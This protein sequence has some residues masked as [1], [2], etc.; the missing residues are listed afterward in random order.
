MKT[1]V[2]LIILTTLIV[3]F[4][5]SQTTIINPATNGGFESG[6]TF[7]LN[8][9]TLV[10]HTTNQWVLG[11]TPGGQSGARCA[12]ISN[13]SPNWTYSNITS[14]TSHFYRSITVP[15]GETIINLSFKWK[16][17]G[18]SGYD[19][20]LVYTN[21]VAPT[22]G[23]PASSTTAWGTA[24][25][26]GGPYNSNTTWQN[27]NI[28]LPAGLA[29]TT[30]NLIFTWQNDG[31]VG[32]NP[33]SAVDDI[34][35]VS[36]P[37]FLMDNTPVTT[38]SGIFVDDGNAFNY[39]TSKDYIKT[40]T[41]SSAGMS[42]Q[43]VF[44]SFVMGDAD[45]Y[46]TIYDGPNIGSPS[47]GTFNSTTGSPGTVVAY[48]ATGQL[49]F[50]WHSDNNG[51]GAGWSANIS[52][53]SPPLVGESCTN[54]Q[55]LSTMTSPF[56]GTTVG[57]ASDISTC[58]SGYPDR[59]F[60][61][62]VPNGCNIDI[63]QSVNNYDSYHY[64][65]YGSSCPGT[66]IYCIDD[67]DTQHN[68]W[69]NTTGSTQRV[70]FIVDGYSGSGTFT[71]EWLLTCCGPPTTVTATASTTL[72]SPGD[73]VTFN[74]SSH[75]GGACSSGNWEYQWEDNLGNVLQAW[76]TTSSY[77]ETMGPVGTY[78]Y[79]LYM[80]CSACPGTITQSSMLTVNVQ[81]CSTC[82]NAEVIGSLPYTYTGATCNMCDNYSSAN[83]C[84]SSYLNGDDFVFKYTPSVDIDIQVDITAAQT[85]S[86]VIISE[87]CPDVGTCV[88]TVTSGS[89]YSSSG[90]PFSLTA[91]TSYYIV[92][93]TYP[94]PQCLTDFT[95]D[96]TI[97]CDPPT[98]ITLSQNP[99]T[100]S[101]TPGTNVTLSY[102]THTGGTCAGT[103]QFQWE[104]DLGN[105]LQ[106]WSTTSNYSQVYNN[107]ETIWLYMRCTDCPGDIFGQS[108][109][110]IVADCEW[111]VC[112]EDSY[113]D[114]WNGGEIEVI[115]DGSSLGF[116]TLASGT[117]P[118][119]YIIYIVDGADITIDYSS[120][121]FS[122]ENEY[123]LFDMDGNPIHD[124][125]VGGSTPAD[126]TYSNAYCGMIPNCVTTT[127]ND[128]LCDGMLEWD[129][130]GFAPDG[131]NLYFGTNNPPTNIINGTDIGNVTS[132]DVSPLIPGQT[133][134]W[135]IIPYNTTYGS[136]VGCSVWSFYYQTAPVTPDANA[137]PPAVSPGGTVLL[138]ATSS[139]PVLWF[140]DKCEGNVISSSTTFST[141]PPYSATY[142]LAAYNGCYS[143]CDSVYVQVVQPCQA[144]A[145]ANGIVDTIQIC[146]GDP[147]DL[148]AAA[149][150][151]YMM[152]NDFNDGSIGVGWNSNCSPMFNNPCLASG[153]GSTYLWVGDAS[154]FPRDLVTQEYT[155]VAGCQICF[156]FAMAIQSDASPCEGPD[157]VDEGVSL[158][159]STDGGTTWTD[160]TY[161]S[162]DGCQYP[163]NIWVGQGTSVNEDCSSDFIDWA[164]YCFTV[165]VG[166]ASSHTQFR[167]H[168]EQVTDYD[169]DHWGLDNVEI[170]CPGNGLEVQWSYGPTVLDP[171]VDVNPTTSTTY[172]VIVDDGFNLGNADT[173]SVFVEV[174]D[175]PT[176][177]DDQICTPGGIATLIASGGAAYNW[178]DAATGGSLVGT[179]STFVINPLLSDQTYWVEFDVPVFT[180][181][182]YTFTN[183]FDG[184]T[185]NDPCGLEASSGNWITNNDG[186][187]RG[188]LAE[189]F[190]TNSSQ[191]V[192]SPAIDVSSFPG[193]IAFYFTHRY[194]TESCCDHGYVVYN[195][196]GAGWTQLPITYGSY[197]G[198]DSQNNDP[199]SSCSSSTSKE[200]YYGNNGGYVTEG[201][202]VDVSTGNSIRF[203]FTF[204]TDGSVGTSSGYEGWLIDE[205]TVQSDGGFAGCPGARAEAHA[206][207]GDLNGSY[208]E[209]AASCYG[210]NDGEATAVA[211]DGLGN[212]VPG[213][214][215]YAWSNGPT[216]VTNSNLIPGNYSVTITD[217][218][219]C[220]TSATATVT[221]PP[222]PTDI[223]DVTAMSGTCNIVSPNNWV[224]IPN[225]LDNTELIASVF[226]ATGG[227]HLY[228]TE[229][230]ATIF[231][232][233]QYYNGMP[234]LQR[235][236]R[237]TPVSNGPATVRVYFSNAEYL[238]LQAADPTITSI[239]DLAVTKCD[240][241]GTWVN[242][243]L[244]PST[245]NNSP[246]GV[247]CYYAE[248]PVTS[249]SKFYIHKNTGQPLPVEL[250]SFRAFCNNDKITF[251]WSTT[252]EINNDHFTL[253]ESKDLVN[254][255]AIKDIEG[256]GNSNETNYYE[257]IINISSEDIL[258]YRLKQVDFDG[259]YK[260]SEVIKVDCYSQ[261]SVNDV[262]IINNSNLDE[263]IVSFNEFNNTEYTIN[264]IDYL[265]RT[266]LVERILPSIENNFVKF[267]KS[268]LSAGLYNIVVQSHSNLVTKQIVIPRK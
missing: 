260:Y 136:P 31:S 264:L 57:Y 104:D 144:T 235:V 94:S 242:C 115:V 204:T 205:V 211:V 202:I 128:T 129:P 184:W 157:E 185:T 263:I 123:Y 171:P 68:T 220:T 42:L 49:T 59:I 214:Y 46:L 75:T 190:S 97:P 146:A 252:I 161:F 258:Y 207:V 70:W 145:Y 150:C 79:Y 133:Y 107:T 85:Y 199:L 73:N 143:E 154:T 101:V 110:V 198:L 58:R 175:A 226:D 225:S 243:I 33:P 66:Q 247:N 56:N 259:N 54:A 238:A 244:M 126:Y 245:F 148:S 194:N 38:C 64:M 177:T 86:G 25:L 51:T 167:F 180:P 53:V 178:Y 158:Q 35:L 5:F 191:V 166:A 251:N 30:T 15:A 22:S 89:G 183:S 9:W 176:V 160:L 213:I 179:G 206:L 4:T 102:N 215:S 17:Q 140:D 208:T 134:Y 90:G 10:N 40:F 44:S 78:N 106:A 255:V 228:L 267:D 257:A 88:G 118:E 120:G 230:E 147:V 236:V 111:T 232:S 8:G 181:I 99:A 20:L 60:Y 55:D 227:N 209:V 18:E 39:T 21:N 100:T 193:T 165:P 67:V 34:S 24:V 224:H 156:D 116:A 250:V 249:F 6:T 142:F 52:C 65:G 109:T 81:V 1:T 200:L 103:W 216:T 83:A 77:V 141:N 124:E 84:G 43:F 182:T 153:D 222:L 223:V 117:G 239:N 13:S 62:D 113:G 41:P 7:P 26:V 37:P 246:I 105:V 253:E 234:Y 138:T 130:V 189:D 229:A 125:G 50:Q 114:G 188:L 266:V 127:L 2:L 186:G 12:Y 173:S 254:F 149:S 135:Q 92:V 197:T 47:L 265:G 132:Y 3:N 74:Y 119:C 96:I 98:G 196:D 91:G 162:P 76:S 152:M 163:S 121:S 233:V 159:W 248:V 169:Y 27:V 80:R 195:L 172:T 241:A 210:N 48:N 192:F 168:Q 23:T 36:S 212:P 93:S 170:S 72:A 262:V 174:V 87:D 45:D 61:I 219:G 217:S 256:F 131:Y 237:V 112:L 137:F 155:V 71:L 139:N 203:A 231:P 201:G 95:I 32:T 19:R 268:M 11:N 164:N 69:T 82:S 29:G 28:T 261:S 16:G 187:I 240:D 63:W 151:D 108:Y 122:S 221:G 14:N 218:Y